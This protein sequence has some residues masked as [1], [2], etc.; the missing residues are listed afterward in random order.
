VIAAVAAVV[1]AT[2][3][4]QDQINGFREIG[5][6]ISTGISAFFLLALAAMN[7]S[8]LRGIWHSFRRARAGEAVW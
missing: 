2:R 7:L 6:A 1:F 5:G 3:A 4:L 8:A